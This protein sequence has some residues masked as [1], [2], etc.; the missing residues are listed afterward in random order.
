MLTDKKLNRRIARLEER[1]ARD[2]QNAERIE[3]RLERARTLLAM[4]V[5]DRPAPFRVTTAFLERSLKGIGGLLPPPAGPIVV[6]VSLGIATAKSLASALRGDDDVMDAVGASVR[7]ALREAGL[8][9]AEIAR[10]LPKILDA[11]DDAID[12]EDVG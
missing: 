9:G 3:R 1:L 11:L 8:P 2:P 5:E 6:S 10:V 7:F 12:R 4:P